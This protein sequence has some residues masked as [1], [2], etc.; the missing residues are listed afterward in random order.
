MPWQL[1]R[2]EDIYVYFLVIIMRDVGQ[3]GGTLGGS[4]FNGGI[5]M[6]ASLVF[7]L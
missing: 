7:R 1:Y 3:V 6:R 2:Q 4:R 5:R